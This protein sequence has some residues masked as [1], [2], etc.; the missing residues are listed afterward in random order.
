M[1]GIQKSVLEETNKE[2]SEKS[3]AQAGTFDHGLTLN[4]LML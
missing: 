1:Q 2:A 4:I 3:I